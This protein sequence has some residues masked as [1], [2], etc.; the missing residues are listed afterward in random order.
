MEQMASQLQTEYQVRFV[1]TPAARNFDLLGDF[2]KYTD[3]TVREAVGF[4]TGYSRW[5]DDH[6][7]ISGVPL[8]TFRHSLEAA[9]T[10]EPVCI[11]LIFI[12]NGT[13][14]ELTTTTTTTTTTPPP[15]TITTTT[16]LRPCNEK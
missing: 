3:A 16:L 2:V 9:N 13:L 11:L 14:T 10:R 7:G 6:W 4:N 8:D 1:W 15:P 12:A 5:M